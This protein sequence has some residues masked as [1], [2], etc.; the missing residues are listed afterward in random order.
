MIHSNTLEETKL[1]QVYIKKAKGDFARVAWTEEVFHM[2]CEHLKAVRDTFD[3]YTLHDVTHVLN[4]QDAMAGL[5]GNRIKELE[6]GEAE[7]LILVSALHDLGMIYTN[8]DRELCF[9]DKVKVQEYYSLH[10]DLQKVDVEDWD[11]VDRQ[12]YLRWLHPFRVVDILQRPVWREQ[13]G[14]RPNEVAPEDV[15]I[16]V[17]RAHGE[18]PGKIRREVTDSNGE[19]RYQHTR[20]IDPLFCAI[21]LRLA[22]ILDFDN[23]RAPSILFSYAGRSLKSVEEWKKHKAS[24]GFTYPDEPSS[25]ELHYGANFTDQS[26][27]RSANV[28]LDWVDDELSNSRSLLPLASSR[29]NQFPFPFQV[30][31]SEI[32]RT[33]Y[34]YGDFRITMDQGQIMDLLVGENLYSDRSVFVREL[35]QNSID[36]TL[37]RAEMDPSFANKISTDEARIDLWEWWDDNGYL[38][39]RID[40]FGS[41]MTRGMLEKYFLKAGNSYYNSQ[42][43][44]RDLNGKR[45]S[46][47]S[48]FG[49]GFLSSFLCG[50]DAYVSTTYWNPEKN[51]REENNAGRRYE[52]RKFGLRL[53]VIGVNGYYTLR[54]QTILDNHPEPLPSPP[55]TAPHPN[56]SNEKDGYRTYPGTSIAIRLDAGKLGATSLLEV[57]KRWV[58]FPCMP[59]YYN[60]KRL[61]MTRTEIVDLAK[62]E[63]GSREYELTDEEKCAFEGFLPEYKGDYPR[64]RDTIELFE[65]NNIAGLPRLKIILCETKVLISEEKRIWRNGYGYKYTGRSALCKPEITIYCAGDDNEDST[66]SFQQKDN[67]RLFSILSNNNIFLSAIHYGWKGIFVY[68]DKLTHHNYSPTIIVIDE[69]EARPDLKANREYLVSAPLNT[70]LTTVTWLEKHFHDADY[71]K[72]F[73]DFSRIPLKEWRTTISEKYLEWVDFLS[74]S[75]F[76]SFKEAFENTLSF[77]GEY[78]KELND[79]GSKSSEFY[80]MRMGESDIRYVFLAY[81]QLHY[82]ITVNYSLKKIYLNEYKLDNN[83]TQFD[84]FPLMPFGYGE[85]EKD[86]SII[87][88]AKARNRVIIMADHPFIKWLLKNAD[89][90][91]NNYSRQFEQI[92]HGLRYYDADKLIVTINQIIAQLSKTSYCQGIDISD[93]PQIDMDDFGDL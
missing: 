17:C 31:R 24:M 60:G 19:L 80:W 13:F 30:N 71:S 90:L 37:L 29:W 28:F 8:D 12:N 44:R 4:V 42:E 64:I 25:D 65:A 73:G 76:L 92:V 82:K 34:D 84:L 11:E 51:I 41:G 61:C 9:A 50:K 38:W 62:N 93:C 35:L 75:R 45:Y 74:W 36:A 46:S 27:E 91:H 43:F 79:D 7:L 33:G 77:I 81:L 1:W 70:L 85:T 52:N 78:P 15:I 59:V 56:E 18:A 16:A 68:H 20:N 58:C 14:R 69:D 87:C 86:C 67:R 48:R 3:N 2:A 23:S 21:L 66:L 89:N 22:D 49:I 5:L 39:F 47:I 55:T 26:I 83:R 53:D 63:C 57:A 72:H 40:D 10:P 32:E 54:N 6:V 88:S